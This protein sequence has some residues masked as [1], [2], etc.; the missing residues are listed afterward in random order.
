V[1]HDIV[2]RLR[3]AGCVF[4][5]EE[6]ELLRSAATSAEQ[7]DTMVGQRV[8]G[9]PLELVVGWA[10]FCGLRIAVTPGVFVPRFRSEFLV[11]EAAALARPGAVVLDL[12]CGSGALGAALRSLVDVGE[13]YA[14]DILP[15]AVRCARGN[16]PGAQVFQGD[17][18]EPL[19]GELRGRVDIL[20]ANT[21]YV[22]SDEIAFLPAEAREH[23]PRVTLNGGADG[24]DLQR[25]VAAEA[26]QWLAPGGHVLVEATEWQAPMTV[27]AFVAGGL[28]TRVTTDEDWGAT[29]VIGT[30]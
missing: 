15:A 2:S 10:E 8:S 28:T 13:L 14:A 22:P 1:P 18:F 23:E 26:A 30:R 20:L 21:P 12:C 25:R 9:V 6:A 17:L 19:P 27:A 7:L 11:R 29:V 4:A 3:A 16:L 5:E 24:L